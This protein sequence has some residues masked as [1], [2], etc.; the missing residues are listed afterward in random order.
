MTVAM[1]EDDRSGTSN[2]EGD[3]VLTPTLPMKM[4]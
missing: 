4:K 3:G 2:V 1:C